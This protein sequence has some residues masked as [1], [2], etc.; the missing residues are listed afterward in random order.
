MSF[1]LSA[2]SPDEAQFIRLRFGLDC[3]RSATL[4]ELAEIMGA[5]ARRTGISESA[6]RNIE[7]SALGRLRAIGHEDGGR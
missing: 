7:Q 1:D 6:V 3:G 5:V 2:L 4:E